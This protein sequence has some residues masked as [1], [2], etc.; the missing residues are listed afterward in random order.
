[1]AKRKLLALIGTIAVAA[2]TGCGSSSEATVS[3]VV[4]LDGNPIPKGG[5]ISFVP[6]AQGTQSYAMSDDS[7]G[8]EVYTG[9]TEGLRAGEYKVTVVAREKSALTMAADGGPPPPGK[10]I[11]PRWYAY[12]DSSGLSFKV[13]PGSNEINLELTSQPPAGWQA[14]GR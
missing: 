12:P 5:M 9:R 3:G 10:E 1:M 13:E 8:Y 4:T 2:A 7:G 11:T 14:R 6:A